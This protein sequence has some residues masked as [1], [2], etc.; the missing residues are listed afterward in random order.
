VTIRILT[1]D[2]SLMIR[3]QLGSALKGAGFSTVE[4]GDGV[5]ALRKLAANPDLRLVI[6]DINMPRMSGIEFLEHLRGQDSP[7]P[8]LMLTTD[9]QPE[10][11]H[12][13]KA[14][15]AKGWIVKP[16]KAELLVAAV[17]R[18]TLKAAA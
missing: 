18:L 13:A 17:R 9:S 14:L 16:F 12:R 15:G 4:A 6:C 11:I 3:Q 2:D 8:V 10:L 1:I 7:P 5:E